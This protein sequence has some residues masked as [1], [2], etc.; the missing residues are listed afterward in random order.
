MCSADEKFF[1]PLTASE[2]RLLDVLCTLSIKNVVDASMEELA[3][4][5]QTSEE[6]VRRALRGLE[7]A[8]LISTTRTK[9]NLGRLSKNRY[10]MVSPSHKNV[11]LLSP[12][13]HKIVDEVTPPAHKNV[14]STAGTGSSNYQTDIVTK[15][16]NKT[17]SYLVPVGTKKLDRKSFIMVN[18]WQDDDNSVGGFGLFDSEAAEKSAGPRLS[19]R[20]PKTRGK[21]PQAEWT[22]SDVASE[23]ASRLYRM[24]PDVPNLVN[25]DK[26][27]GALSKMRKQYDSNALIELEIMK[28]FFEDPWVANQGKDNPAWIAG[29]FLKMFANHFDQALR[30]LGL[31]ERKG[32]TEEAMEDIPHSDFVYASDGRRFD[33]SMPGR[34]AL[35][36]HEDKLRK[37]VNG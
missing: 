31:P 4:F 1:T 27:R 28:I 34:L 21:R 33:N 12:P 11:D 2:Y 10:E 17:T 37:K 9:R 6:S 15:E 13:P 24:I 18:R 30:N 22:S 26:V 35:Q 3:R 20:D 23:F 7:S 29:R 8:S 5:A 36:K 25:T 14:G 32:P 19:K 16:T